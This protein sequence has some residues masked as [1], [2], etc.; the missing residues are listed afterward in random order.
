VIKERKKPI[1]PHIY[2]DWQSMQD[3]W[4]PMFNKVIAKSQELGIFD[5]LGMWQ[6]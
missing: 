5:L 4:D 2:V 1:T 3:K 6:D